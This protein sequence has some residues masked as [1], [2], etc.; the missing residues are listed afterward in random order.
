MQTNLSST[1][2]LIRNAYWTRLT[3]VPHCDATC[4]NSTQLTLQLKPTN[5]SNAGVPGWRVERGQYCLSA[6]KQTNKN[7]TGLSWECPQWAAA[8]VYTVTLRLVGRR[9]GVAVFGLSVN[10]IIIILRRRR[11]FFT[12]TSNRKQHNTYSKGQPTLGSW[13]RALAFKSTSSTSV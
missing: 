1:T 5:Q 10:I 4:A 2:F 13:S 12:T 6:N 3:C 8:H 9:V 7:R 11:T